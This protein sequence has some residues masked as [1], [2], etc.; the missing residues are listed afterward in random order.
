M[1]ASVAVSELR[2]RIA[3]REWRLPVVSG[4]ALV[5]ASAFA[6]QLAG[7]LFNAVGAHTL[8]PSKYGALA[9]TIGLLALLAPVMLAVQAVAS[10]ETTS[11]LARD[12]DGALAPMVR[13]YGWRVCLSS[14][15]LGG[16]F[17]ALAS[18]I[19][20]EFHLGSP[21][22]VRLAG[23]CVAVYVPS[24]FLS[25]ILQGAERFGRFAL[26]TVLEATA[27]IVFAV[28]LLGLVW[29]APSAGLL[30]IALSAL[31][32]LVINVVLVHG[33]LPRQPHLAVATRLSAGYSLT[34]L[35]TFG[36][37]AVLLSVDT[38]VGKRYLPAEQAGLYAGISL[39]GKIVFF[40]TSA[41]AVVAF[42]IFSRHQDLGRDGVRS[43]GIA[44]LT[45]LAII[46]TCVLVLVV[47][48]GLVVSALLG[49]R[50]RAADQYAPWMG[51]TFGLYAV[52]Y[53]CSTYLLARRH[54]G[55]IAALGVAVAVQ[56]AGFYG[57]HSTIDQLIA[58]EALAFWVAIVGSLVVLTLS[59]PRD[60]VRDVAPPDR[61]PGS[62][63]PVAGPLS[64]H[65]VAVDGARDR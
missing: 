26:E 58:V 57:F 61:E 17:A 65:D 28:V 30:A 22:G 8:G 52:A 55:V 49:P 41:L 6:W 33:Y 53:L 37:L 4:A 14:C 45:A 38:L 29:K 62:V 54:R 31:C 51:A 46:A 63:P 64:T 25:G 48:P 39:T 34:T 19:A 2:A 35:L 23:L 40:A 5:F 13:R 59:R 32:G 10:R 20:A 44:T 56:L 47:A 3:S 60:S 7:F 15:A 50:Y 12:V 21:W 9:A 42:P 36:L 1:S 43:L 18:P 16:T 11:L 27:K 24:H